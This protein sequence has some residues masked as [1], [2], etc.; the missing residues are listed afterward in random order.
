MRRADVARGT[1][2]IAHP[3]LRPEVRDAGPWETLLAG[4]ALR[5]AAEVPPLAEEVEAWER[6]VARFSAV[7]DVEGG[8]SRGVVYVHPTECLSLL[9][10]HAGILRAHLRSCHSAALASDIGVLARLALAVPE[11]RELRVTVGSLHADAS[12]GLPSLLSQSARTA[13]PRPRVVLFEGPD[14]V[15]KTTLL[16]AFRS[17]LSPAETHPALWDR[18]FLSARVYDR[19]FQRAE[20]GEALLR[21]VLF[22]ADVDICL[23]THP[24]GVGDHSGPGVPWYEWEH[25]AKWAA[26]RGCRVHKFISR[27]ATPDVMAIKL[28]ALAGYRFREVSK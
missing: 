24:P 21:A 27:S 7:L 5:A 10:L 11:T 4:E 6:I 9:H 1:F 2:P 28:A 13:A 8:S 19:H 23:I 20:S 18:M 22:A 12:P 17:A 25:A 3:P 26:E 15:G 14:G 16:K